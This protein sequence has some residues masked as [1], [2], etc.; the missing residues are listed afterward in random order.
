MG[1]S[2]R[3]I[4]A[5]FPSRCRLRCESV[6]SPA[7]RI[8]PRNWRILKILTTVS[9]SEYAERAVETVLAE[10]RHAKHLE[11]LRGRLAEATHGAYALLDRMGA[12]V[13]VRP[14]HSLFIWVRWPGFADAQALAQS[15]LDMDI[16]MA[17]GNIFSVDRERISPWS[18]CNPHA[19]Q[20]RGSRGRWSGFVADIAVQPCA[21]LA[22]SMRA[23]H[24][25][26]A[27][28][29]DRPRRQRCCASGFSA[30]PWWGSRP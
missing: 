14:E 22:F 21:P 27:G 26:L 24:A 8:W 9:S 30:C 3:F 29:V 17:P 16:V 12:E 28:C 18:R 23:G 13:F 2:A 20:I 6:L 1:W 15:M 10:R 25:C 4:L 5:A 11:Q 7:A 19:V